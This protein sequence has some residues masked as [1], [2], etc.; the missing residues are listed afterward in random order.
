MVRAT[1]SLY[2]VLMVVSNSNDYKNMSILSTHDS[3]CD[4]NQ[5]ESIISSDDNISEYVLAAK[6]CSQTT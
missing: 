1:A 6:D 4:D 5:S 3:N 2:L